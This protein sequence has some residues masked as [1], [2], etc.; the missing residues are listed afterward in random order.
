MEHDLLILEEPAAAIVIV[1]DDGG[2]GVHPLGR[3]AGAEKPSR[4]CKGPGAGLDWAELS[5]PTDTIQ[6]T[7]SYLVKAIVQYPG[8]VLVSEIRYSIAFEVK[9]ALPDYEL[10][11]SKLASI[12]AIA[13]S[14]DVSGGRQVLVHVTPIR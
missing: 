3:G 6:R 4:P 10:V 8:R 14:A 5:D 7:I 13:V 9:V 11:V 12:R 1:A 2:A